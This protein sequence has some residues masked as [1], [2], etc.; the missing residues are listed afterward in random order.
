MVQVSLADRY[1][2]ANEVL[3]ALNNRSVRATLKAYVDQKYAISKTEPIGDRSSYPA[4]IDWA[5]G[6]QG[7]L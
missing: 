2:S 4:A 7:T 6:I 5:L 1:Q 3:N